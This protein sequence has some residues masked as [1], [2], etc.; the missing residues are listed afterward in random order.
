MLRVALIVAAILACVL[1][2]APARAFECKC[3]P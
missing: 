1:S 2:A 3:S